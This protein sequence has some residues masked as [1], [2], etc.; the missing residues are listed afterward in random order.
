MANARF[1]IFLLLLI[2]VGSVACN[3]VQRIKDRQQTY[4]LDAATDT[5]RKLIRWGYYD[6]A[7]QYIRP[8]DGDAPEVNVEEAGRFKVTHYTI[9]N[10]IVADDLQD[11]EVTASIEYYEVESG[12]AKTI[13]DLQHWWF[14]PEEKR[15]YQ[16]SGLPDFVGGFR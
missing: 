5:Y 3:P 8:R 4:D 11:A 2:V 14:E 7:V 9:T 13:R 16:E 10:T 6:Q 12:V 1:R 15:W